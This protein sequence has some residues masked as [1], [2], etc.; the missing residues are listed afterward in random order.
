M[1]VRR[2]VE[3]VL[4]TLPSDDGE[5]LTLGPLIHNPQAID[6]LS[7]KRVRAIDTPELRRGSTIVIRTHGITPEVKKLLDEREAHIVDATCPRVKRVQN[8]IK[9]H[10]IKTIGAQ[11][12]NMSNRSIKDFECERFIITETFQYMG[13]IFIPKLQKLQ[14][15]IAVNYFLER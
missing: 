4:K 12:Q 2:A 10:G 3:L 8:I 13:N 9:K 11:L 5:V 14:A 15:I 6:L 7:K 1:G